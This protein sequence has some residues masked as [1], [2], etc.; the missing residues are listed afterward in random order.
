MAFHF[1]NGT[2]K[3]NYHTASPNKFKKAMQC[4][5]SFNWEEIDDSTDWPKKFKCKITGIIAT[6]MKADDPVMFVNDEYLL[7]DI[8]EVIVK[9]IIE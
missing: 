4:T 8:D 7:L 3:K 1:R 2:D 6:K 9:D 5:Q